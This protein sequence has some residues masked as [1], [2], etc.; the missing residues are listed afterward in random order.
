M[1]LSALVERFSVS[2]MFDFP[3]NSVQE[4][5]PFSQGS[6]TVCVQPFQDVQEQKKEQIGEKMDPGKLGCSQVGGEFSVCS[7]HCEVGR[8]QCTV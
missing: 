1:L 7:V 4:D 3:P 8:V 5:S 2:R 6:F